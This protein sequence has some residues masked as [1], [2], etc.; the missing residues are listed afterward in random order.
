MKKFDDEMRVYGEVIR[1]SGNPVS[2][3]TLVT[4]HAGVCRISRSARPR[5][6]RPRRRT[7]HPTETI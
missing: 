2:G 7:A 4:Q 3:L 6:S 5:D 1:S